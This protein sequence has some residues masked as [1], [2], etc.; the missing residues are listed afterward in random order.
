MTDLSVAERADDPAPAPSAPAAPARALPVADRARM[1]AETR[2]I[3]RRHRARLA[4]VV[5]VHGA[6][7]VAGLCVPYLVGLVVDGLAGGMAPA[8]ADLLVALVAGAVVLHAAI[9]YAAV[10]ASARL[11]ER[12]LAELREDFVSRVLRLPLAVVERAGTGDLVSRTSRDLD[13]LARAVRFA[14]PDTVIAGVTL[15][16]TLGAIAL[17]HPV[18]LLAVLPAAPLLVLSTRWYLRRAGTGYQREMAAY[19]T[20][21]QGLADTVEGART[22]VAL[23]R[24]RLRRERTDADIAGSYTAERYTLWLRSLWFP[25]LEIGYV[26][27]TVAA[28]LGGGW[29]YFADVLTLGQAVAA[30]LYFQQVIEP[31]DRFVSQIDTLQV[32]AAALRRLLGVAAVDDAPAAP[33]AESAEAAPADAAA[34]GG[35]LRVRGLRFGYRAGADVLHGIDLDVRPGERLAVVGPSGAGKSTLGR[36]LAG[37]HTPREGAITLDGR[38][39][40]SWP[41]EELRSRIA[42]VSQEHHVF[43]TSLRDNVAMVRAGDADDAAVWAALEAVEAAGWVRELPEGLDTAVGSGGRS[44]SPAQAQQLALA[45]LVLADPHTLILDEATS[46][47]DPRAARQLERSLAAVL[48]GRTVIA[49][50]HRLHTAHDADRVAVVEGGRITEL[51]GHEELVARDGSYAALWRS[52]HG[53]D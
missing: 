47:L 15:V 22:V 31:L 24:V 5:S 40:G 43:R 2:R 48:R 11:G 14:A 23:G 19:S 46:L 17:V 18:L 36:L 38:E 28:L 7:T 16:F 39:L 34:R 51:G 35:E 45:R 21:T 53:R 41:P 42:L 29:L 37:I 50:A 33:A 32:G 1:L 49:I 12:V 13:Q 8:R 30:T 20:L 44:L 4:R 25:A 10:A 3:V 52:W 27:P 26:I 6:A 9:T